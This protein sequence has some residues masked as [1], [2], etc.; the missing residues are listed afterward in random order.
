MQSSQ[1][2]L[3]QCQYPVASA[4]TPPHR[5]MGN[6]LTFILKPTHSCTLQ[7]SYCYVSDLAETGYMKDNVLSALFSKAASHYGDK[8]AIRFLWHGGEP[9][10]MKRDFF[11]RAV[12]LQKQILQSCVY[13]N[14]MQTNGTLLT[15]D[16]LE[17]LCD[18]NFSIGLSLDGPKEYHDTNRS[19]KNGDGSFNAVMS[20]LSLCR[21][22]SIP[23]G[24]ICVVTRTNID[25]LIHLYGFFAEHK[26]HVGFNPLVLEASSHK[27]SALAIS[28][29]EYAL[30][31]IALFDHWFYTDYIIQVNPLWEMIG[32][33]LFY[34]TRSCMFSG[35][36]QEDFISV[37]PQGDIYPCGRFDGDRRFWLGNILSDTMPVIEERRRALNLD[38]RD[39]ETCG[40]CQY[41]RIC[42]GGCPHDALVMCGDAR[43]KTFYCTAYR[44]LYDH[45]SDALSHLIGS[46]FSPGNGQHLDKRRVLDLKN[47]VLNDV[48]KRR[49]VTPET[50]WF[51][52][53]SHTD[54]NDRSYHDHT[55][56]RDYSDYREKGCHG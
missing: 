12:T 43:K 29:E 27:H 16:T 31:L 35:R 28:P 2:S 50:A 52:D 9:L 56:H 26:I 38:Q 6:C 55:D 20:A 46:D 37:G 14:S 49:K 23:T 10:L 41:R 44:M 32:N 30:S 47:G 24:V 34:R 1:A 53:R 40:S 21:N 54:H 19:F 51:L 11:E 13:E 17:F 45:I 36:C 22:A 8:Q 33:L 4:R 7:C 39:L 18:N 5:S 25:N 42:N 48:I 15:E 3:T